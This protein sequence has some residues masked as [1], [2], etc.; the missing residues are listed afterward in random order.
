[1]ISYSQL[2]KGD[3]IIIEKAPYEIIEASSMF[4]GRGHSVLQVKLKKLK[5]GEI[6]SKTIRPSDSFKEAE[7][8]KIDLKFIYSHRGEYV[9]CKKEN[10]SE[11]FSFTKEKLGSSADF[12]KE[13]LEVQGIVF[14]DKIINIVL[15]VKVYLKIKQSPPGVKG[16]TAEGG[17]KT[18]TLETGFKINVPLFINEGDIIEVNTEKEEYVRRVEKNSSGR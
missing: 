17:T 6:I 4:K 7:I 15:P 3:R 12:L 5:T 1:M 10:P 18:A 8:T 11:R 16:N 14:Q 9:F 2:E 13:G